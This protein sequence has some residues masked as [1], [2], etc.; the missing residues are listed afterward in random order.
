MAR[1][2]TIRDEGAF[3]IDWFYNKCT[4]CT[5]HISWLCIWMRFAW[6]RSEMV[7]CTLMPW[8]A[9]IRRLLWI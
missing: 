4:K 3:S 1:Y 6:R 5:F 7:C 8:R 9:S 2:Q